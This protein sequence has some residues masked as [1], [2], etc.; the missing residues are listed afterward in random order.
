[1]TRGKPLLRLEID[2]KDHIDLKLRY[3]GVMLSSFFVQCLILV[4]V[5]ATVLEITRASCLCW[6]KF[7]IICYG[8]VNSKDCSVVSVCLS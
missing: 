5:H 2:F 1:M 7:C 6:L 4:I 3:D 8:Q